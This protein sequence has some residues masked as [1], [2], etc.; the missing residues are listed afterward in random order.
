M[1]PH[2]TRTG[3][4]AQRSEIALRL[5]AILILTVSLVGAQPVNVARAAGTAVG[6][7]TA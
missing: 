2:T 6:T 3:A 5:L 7:V 1:N 4:A